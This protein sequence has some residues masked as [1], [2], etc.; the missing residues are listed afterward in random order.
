MNSDSELMS[1]ED[2]MSAR[3]LKVSDFLDDPNWPSATLA[4]LVTESNDT[5][6]VNTQD[7]LLCGPAWLDSLKARQLDPENI[8]AQLPLG[9]HW[10]RLFTDAILLKVL[11]ILDAQTGNK[12]LQDATKSLSG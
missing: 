10:R 7:L 2:N 5:S 11:G 8:R 12:K 6:E 9:R 4:A 3:S 1:P